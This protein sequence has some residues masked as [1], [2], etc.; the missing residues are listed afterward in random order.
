MNSASHIGKFIGGMQQK[1][2]TD[3]K[4]GNNAVTDFKYRSAT[5]DLSSG[6]ITVEDKPCEDSEDFLGGIG[7]IFKI[8]SHHDVSDPYAPSS[9]LVMELGCFSGTNLMTGLRT[10]FGGY[11][12][13][14]ST[15][16]GAPSAMYSAGS[17]KFGTKVACAG[18]DEII[19]IGR[20]DKPVTLV[21]KSDTLGGPAQAWNSW[22]PLLLSWAKDSHEKMMA[23]AYEYDDAHF[24]VIGPPGENYETNRMASIVLE[25]G[26][27][28]QIETNANRGSAGVAVS[29]A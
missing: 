25:Y 6:S 24:A 19:F 13:L 7:R 21:I 5:V 27:P 14:K 17:G 29:A 18:I 11:S 8:L 9:P 15:L 23:L 12:P 26:K 16:A 22:M 4:N 3:A 28:T 1:M 10:F 20:S 2:W